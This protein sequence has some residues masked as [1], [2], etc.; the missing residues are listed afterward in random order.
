MAREAALAAGNWK[1][2]ERAIGSMTPEKLGA[3]E[4]AYWLGRAKIAQG[5]R[6]EGEKVLSSITGHHTFYG[7]LACDA[8]N[9]PYPGDGARPSVAE[10]DVR[11]WMQNPSII[12]AVL[13]RRLGLYSMASANGTG[14]FATRRSRSSS[15]PLNMPAGS[16]SLTA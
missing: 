11:Q 10:S 16:D 6:S 8:L 15:R 12:R 14:R 5:D 4:S 2:V 7:K 9:V 13:L 3:D 1:E